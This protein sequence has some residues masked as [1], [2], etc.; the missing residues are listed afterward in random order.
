MNPD[1][2]AASVEGHTLVRGV[3][4]SGVPRPNRRHPGTFREAITVANGLM[5]DLQARVWSE[6][7]SSCRW[8]PGP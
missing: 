3:R 6:D 4:T 5:Y 2:D 7:V 1:S 8:W